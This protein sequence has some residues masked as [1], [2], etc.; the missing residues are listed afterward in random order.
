MSVEKL[1]KVLVIGHTSLKN[2]FLDQLHAE[3][4]IQIE[5]VQDLEPEIEFPLESDFND[6]DLEEIL[7]KIG[8]LINLFEKYKEKPGFLTGL[9]DSKIELT[10][11]EFEEVISNF[12]VLEI[13]TKFHEIYSKINNLYIH[14]NNLL[15]TQEKLRQWTDLEIPLELS[16][17][18]I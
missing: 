13:Y 16:L 6:K 7:K 4:I 3:E 9:L 5:K 17:I 14:N 10:R 8:F 12:D 1:K 18:H 11:A 2:R 15:V